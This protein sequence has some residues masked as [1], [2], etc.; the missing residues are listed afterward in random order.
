M[1]ALAVSAQRPSR[2]LGVFHTIPVNAASVI[3]AGSLVMVD[4]DG[5][6]RPAAALASNQGCLGVATASV[7]GGAADG[8]TSVVVQE[9][10]YLFTATSAAQTNLNEL[11]YAS[12]DNDVDE[13]Q[14]ANEP[15]AGR[16]VQYVSATSV[17]LFVGRNP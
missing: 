8:D 3:Y 4:A 16:L 6:A 10:E 1:V 11:F 17:W 14:G 5:F 13:T 12:T 2:K 9:G 15:V 7:T